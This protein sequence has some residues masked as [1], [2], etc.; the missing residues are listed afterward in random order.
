MRSLNPSVYIPGSCTL[1]TNTGPQF[2]ANCSSTAAGAAANVDLRRALTMQNYATGKYLG[3]VDEHT[4]V[5]DQKYNGLVLSL[6][7]RSANGITAGANY[8][9]SKCTGLPT[10]GGGTPNVNSGYTDPTTRT[11]TA[12]RAIRT[13][14]TTSTSRPARRRRSSTARRRAGWG[15]TGGCRASSAPTRARRSR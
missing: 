1:Q 10:Q 6:N 14:G 3:V 7:R 2:F 5:G 11:T 9:L 13:A 8:T 15:R 12:A 4:S